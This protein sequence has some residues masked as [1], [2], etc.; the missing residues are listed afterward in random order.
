[1]LEIASA[2][3]DKDVATFVIEPN[4]CALQI[5]GRGL[6][7]YRPVRFRFAKIRRVFGISLMLVIGMLLGSLKIRAKRT[8][9]DGLKIDIDGGVNAKTFIHRAV[10][11]DRGDHLLADVIDRVSLPLGVLPAADD[12]LFPSCTG[13]SFAADEIKIAHPIERVIAR[14]QRRSPICPGR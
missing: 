7:G 1:M 6:I 8:L 10:P 5:L 4:Y 14:L 11:A 3:E 13:A 12:N 2:D 9:S